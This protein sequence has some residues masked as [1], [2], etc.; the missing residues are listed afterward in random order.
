MQALNFAFKDYFKRLFNKNKD[1]DGYFAW[2]IGNV[3]SGGL[4][5]SCSLLF[6]Y[7]MDYARTRLTNDLHNHKNGGVK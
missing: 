2:F 6:V 1:I 4:A 7:S 5:G 3:A